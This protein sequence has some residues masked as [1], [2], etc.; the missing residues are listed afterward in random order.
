LDVNHSDA[1]RR[2]RKARALGADL[3]A[4]PRLWAHLDE[5]A[6]R[7]EGGQI[8]RCLR[9]GVVAGDRGDERLVGKD[10]MGEI[11]R[12]LIGEQADE[13]HIELAG[14]HLVGHVPAAG[15]ADAAVSAEP[16]EE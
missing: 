12:H 3:A 16:I 8:G 14:A 4:Q 9:E 5:G 15:V 10:P 6:L 2:V 7:G 1:A 13:R 11:A